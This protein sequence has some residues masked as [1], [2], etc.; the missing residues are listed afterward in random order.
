MREPHHS[1]ERETWKGE[2]R[3]TREREI[4][5]RG[6]RK[7]EIQSERENGEGPRERERESKIEIKKNGV[8]HSEEGDE[9]Y[10]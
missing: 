3:G 1:R 5:G 7:R 4:R 10:I 9:L 8:M 2:Q 6:T